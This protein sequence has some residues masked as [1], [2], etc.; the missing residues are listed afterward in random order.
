[1]IIDIVL[2]AYALLLILGGFIGFKKGSKIS[3]V[4][5]VASGILVLVG[6]WLL[7]FNPR[8]AWIFLICLNVLLSLS[9][10]SRLIK[11]RKLMPSGMLLIITLVVLVFCLFHL[12]HA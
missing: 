6:I 10:T 4:M 3:L 7:T 12:N 5:G 8:L 9:F 11:T 1:M 2:I